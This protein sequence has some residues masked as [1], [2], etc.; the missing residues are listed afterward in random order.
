MRFLQGIRVVEVGTLLPGA[1][2][3]S[4]LKNLGASVVR[5]VP[6]ADGHKG[7]LPL[8]FLQPLNKGK[9]ILSL[10]L[11]SERDR[12]RLHRELARADIL[13]LG[14]RP[15]ALAKFDLTIKSLQRRHRRLIICS[16]VGFPRGPYAE[17]AG[18]DLNYLALAGVLGLNRAP[19]ASSVIPPIPLADLVGGAM[20]AVIRCLAALTARSKTKKGTAVEVCMTDGVYELLE[21]KKTDVLGLL[22]G[23]L[24]RYNVYA[25]ADGG[26]VA[27]AALEPKFWIHFCEVVGH[28]EWQRWAQ[29]FDEPLSEE[30]KKLFLSR[31]LAH[32]RDLGLKHDIC[33]VPVL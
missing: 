6:P 32:W 28:P 24:P 16:I 5:V 15:Q 4:L 18:H 10:D 21:F 29:T 20:R 14:L 31:P 26:A 17:K 3:A 11:K 33:L 8:T 22:D 9:K 30:L 7:G 25:C 19:G 12:S 13:L 1:Q 27:L 23:K 2:A